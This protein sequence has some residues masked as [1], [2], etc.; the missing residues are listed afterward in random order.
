MTLLTRLTIIILCLK[1]DFVIVA[2][3]IVDIV[4]DKLDFI[5]TSMRFISAATD[6]HC[7]TSKLK[8]ILKIKNKR[9]AESLNE[10]CIHQKLDSYE[11]AKN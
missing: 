10:N 8:E 4:I 1:I 6:T 3:T 7:I 2:T 5:M 11:I 9:S